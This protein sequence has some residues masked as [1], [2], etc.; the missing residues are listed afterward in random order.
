M[1]DRAY[2]INWDKA[3]FDSPINDLLS[4]YQKYYHEMNLFDVLKLYEKQNKLSKLEKELLLARISIPKIIKFSQDTL[5]DVK[6]I[7]R[8]M[9][10]LK[11]VN[12]EIQR[13]EKSLNN[14]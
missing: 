13:Y 6:E 1:S 7:N 12:E 3:C 8:E 10:F 14:T 4:F 2:L 11:K 5:N 9:L